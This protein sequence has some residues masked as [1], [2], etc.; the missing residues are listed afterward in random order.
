MQYFVTLGYSTDSFVKNRIE[1]VVS[2]L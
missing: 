2:L 1:P